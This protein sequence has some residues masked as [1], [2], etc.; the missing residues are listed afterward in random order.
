MLRA[1]FRL[2]ALR[3]PGVLP[4]LAA[5]ERAERRAYA[6]AVTALFQSLGIAPPAPPQQLALILQS[7]DEWTTH[8]HAIDPDDVPRAAYFDSLELLFRAAV[9]LAGEPR[10]PTGGGT[11]SKTDTRGRSTTP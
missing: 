3:D 10:S 7:L 1:E 2:H 9:A 6:R 8:A 4:R 11:R 5:R